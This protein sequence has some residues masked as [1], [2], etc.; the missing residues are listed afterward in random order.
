M[1]PQRIMK[2][3]KAFIK[4]FEAPQRRVQIK[5]KLIFISIQ[6]SEMHRTG[7]VKP[8]NKHAWELSLLPIS[9]MKIKIE[10][11]HG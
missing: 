7:R 3:L 9:D 1:V 10:T 8:M 2:A 6:L 4:P 11:H 5:I